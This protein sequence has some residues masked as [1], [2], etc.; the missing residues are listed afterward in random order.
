VWISGFL[1]PCGVVFSG[2]YFCLVVVWLGWRKW[3][4]C[5]T[6]GGRG[7][8]FYC[9]KVV[10]FGHNRF[11]K[12]SEMFEELVGVVVGFTLLADKCVIFLG[13]HWALE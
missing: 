8:G 3:V 11:S 6:G 5:G 1:W 13:A 2:W 4:V 9:E 12:G 7:G 10:P